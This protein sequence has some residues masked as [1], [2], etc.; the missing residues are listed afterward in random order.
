MSQ[1][2][3]LTFQERVGVSPGLLIS[4]KKVECAECDVR[5]SCDR[6]LE[7]M[8]FCF[9]EEKEDM[10]DSPELYFIKKALRRTAHVVSQSSGGA[11]LIKAGKRIYSEAHSAVYVPEPRYK[12]ATLICSDV[13]VFK[14][15][16]TSGLK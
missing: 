9:N 2:K 16:L 7:Q 14:A 1:E 5:K 3:K 10:K 4:W 11:A 12:G 6:S 15:C 13:E 8:V